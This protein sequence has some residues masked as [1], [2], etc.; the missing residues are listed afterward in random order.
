MVAAEVVLSEE[1]TPAKLGGAHP[2]ALWPGLRP[3][4]GE[5]TGEAR[6]PCAE[7]PSDRSRSHIRHLPVEERQA[8]DEVLHAFALALTLGAAWPVVW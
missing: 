6:R 1:S 5:A 7:P 4:S 3:E 8:P 2:P